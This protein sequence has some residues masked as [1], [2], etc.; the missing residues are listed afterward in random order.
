MCDFSRILEKIEI[1]FLIIINHRHITNTMS[2]EQTQRQMTEAE[3]VAFERSQRHNTQETVKGAK[4][5]GKNSDSIGY[6]GV[7]CDCGWTFRRQDDEKATNMALR[8]HTKVCKVAQATFGQNG[9][10]QRVKII[11]GKK[12]IIGTAVERI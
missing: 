9:L 4:T 6:Y 8:L 2:V 10:D 11:T 1:L 3:K 5:K 12:G 7:S